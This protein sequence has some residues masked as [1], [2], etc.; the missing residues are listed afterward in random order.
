LS[1]PYSPPK[2]AVSE[3]VEPPL[4]RSVRI[5]RALAIA[6][7]VLIGLIPLLF[8]FIPRRQPGTLLVTAVVSVPILLF[9]GTSILALTSRMAERAVR[10]SAMLLNG[11]AAAFF[12]YLFFARSGGT[13]IAMLLVI[14]AILNMLAIDELRRARAPLA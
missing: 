13:E 1:N 8:L 7:C 6:G 5:L 11:A 3:P 2:A 10:W 9:S 4:P 12:G 14:P